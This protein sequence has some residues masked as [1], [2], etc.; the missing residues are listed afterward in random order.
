MSRLHNV[1]IYSSKKHIL[2]EMDTREITHLVMFASMQ[3]ATLKGNN[4]SL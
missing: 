3:G 1:I 2:K 4:L